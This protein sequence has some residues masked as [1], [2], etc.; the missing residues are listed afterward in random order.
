M[1]RAKKGDGYR[2]VMEDMMLQ[3]AMMQMLGMNPECTCGHEH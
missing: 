1:V 2:M 3:V